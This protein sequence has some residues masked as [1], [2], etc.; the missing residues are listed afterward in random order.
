MIEDASHPVMILIRGL[1]GSGKSYIAAELQKVIG[2]DKVVLLDPDMIDFTSPE[3]LA[4]VA[5]LREEGVDESLFAYR[6][7][8]G[9]AYKGIA[10]HKVIIWNQA[11][12][13][14]EIFNKMVAKFTTQADEH[15]TILPILV[16]EVETDT[17]L[18]KER[19]IKRMQAGGHGLSEGTFERFNNDYKSFASA[20]YNTVTVQGSDAVETSVATIMNSLTSLN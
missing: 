2:Y 4:H 19:V 16:V 18:A 13:N 1:P 3:Y 5:A 6:F 12:T 9:K 7:L 11:F 15:Q 10:E 14:L 20:G 17:S 8:R